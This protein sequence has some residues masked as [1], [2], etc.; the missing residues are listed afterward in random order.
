MLA[1]TYY[2]EAIFYGQSYLHNTILNDFGPVLDV[3]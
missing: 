1:S 2:V 3:F